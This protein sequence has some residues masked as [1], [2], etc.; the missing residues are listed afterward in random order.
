[1]VDTFGELYKPDLDRLLQKASE[2]NILILGA[3]RPD[4]MLER[5]KTIRDCL[6]QRGF[7]N[8]YLVADFPDD[9]P[10]YHKEN[11]INWTRK[12]NLLMSRS[13]INIFIFLA[14]CDN[15]G[16]VDEFNYFC[17]EIGEFFRCIVLYEEGQFSSMSTRISAKIKDFNLRNT[18]VKEGEDM[19]ICDVAFGLINYILMKEQNRIY[20]DLFF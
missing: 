7:I 1:M 4:S 18:A 3:Y 13:D 14:N 5:L 9:K 2:L 10:R 20:R 12:S 19:V 11:D 15:S 16:P 17:Y 8:T 6:R